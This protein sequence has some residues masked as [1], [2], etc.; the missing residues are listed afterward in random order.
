MSKCKR[1][2]V[3]ICKGGS[4]EQ[5]VRKSRFLA[6][7]EPCQSVEQADAFIERV[8]DRKANHNCWA[9]RIGEKVRYN[10]DGEPGGTAGRPILS[11]IDGAELD[12]VAVVVTRYF[13]GI[14]LGTGGLVRAYG[15]TA[16]ACLDQLDKAVQIIP[17][18]TNVQLPVE[19]QALVYQALT[20]LDS[21]VKSTHYDEGGLARLTIEID[22]EHLESFM[23]TLINS[24]RGQAQFDP[25]HCDPSDQRQD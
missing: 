24:S 20:G 4:L 7:A 22:P 23:T 13:G 5:V 19:M 10:D 9:Y 16:S 25:D 21:H 18:E 12:L 8:S 11:A 14:K 2:L 15:G 1:Q 17:V 3:T 6:W